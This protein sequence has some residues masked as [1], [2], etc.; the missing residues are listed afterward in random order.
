MKKWILLQKGGDFDRISEKFQ[1]SPVLARL[2]RNRELRRDEEIDGFLHSRIEDLHDPALLKDM[3]EAAALILRKIKEEKW[4]RIVGDYDID[5]VMSTY[6]LLS[7]IRR[8]GGRTD[9]KLPHRIKD[10]YG[11]NQAIIEECHLDG[12]DTILTCDNGI[13]AR[14]EIALAKKY[15]MTVIITDHH[16]V[17][18]L[19]E[20]SESQEE[21]QEGKDQCEEKGEKVYQ[22][23][24][25]D[26]IIN[27]K[28]PDCEYPFKGICG[29][30]VAYKFIQELYRQAGLP[31]DTVQE[32]LEFAAI[33]T[34]GDVMEL[35][36]ENRIVVK[37]GLERLAETKNEGLYALLR[38]QKLLGKKLTPYHIGFVL[39]PCINASGRLDTAQRALELLESAGDKAKKLAEELRGFNEA[40]KAMT[41]EAV[42][43]AK[44]IVEA[45]K[46]QAKEKEQAAES[47]DPQENHVLVIYLEDCHESLAGIVAGRIKEQYYKPTIV[48][49]KGEEG[50][51]GSGRSI[52]GYSMFEELSGCKDLFSKFGGHP[53]AAGLT[54]K[55]ENYRE[56]ERRLNEQERLTQDDLTPKIT[57]DME[58]PFSYLTMELMEQ[59][60]QLEPYG[61][62]NSRPLFALRGV[63]ILKKQ[64]IGQE[65]QY[66]RLSLEDA[67]GSRLSGMVFRE[68]EALREEDA[69]CITIAYYPEL[70]EFRGRS[71]IQIIIEEYLIA[72]K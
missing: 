60:N 30:L 9:V 28:R 50:L 29:G 64:T 35:K 10:G 25:A 18:F 16:E 2:L 37:L 19:L 23:P 52:P 68:T 66:V 56:L 8:L 40:R 62:G 57:L 24:P 13:A 14:E 41:T 26:Y 69:A 63:K 36:D 6:I 4:I 65:G 17:P 59:L 53:M 70:N 7:G 3:T 20:K 32:Y 51:K 11:L 54:L 71:Q 34:V 15:G 43:A 48:L 1:I 31:D 27:P 5:G 39:G 22:L 21:K 46:R 49:T 42:E 45:G 67:Y 38:E 72:K 12:V 55:D 44:Q 47:G 58:L 61:N 33:A